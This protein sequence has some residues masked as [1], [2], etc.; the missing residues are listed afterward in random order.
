MS[1]IALARQW[2]PRAFAQLVGQDH[3]NKALIKSL[4]QQRLHHAYLFTGTRG[5]G[6]TSV[7]RLFAKALNCLQGIT[8]EPCLQCD[9]CVAIEEGRFIDLLEID[10]AS[11]TRVEDT[12][13]ILENVH[14]APTSGRFKIYLIDEVHMLSQHSFNALLKVIE[15]PPPHI[16]FL[17][18]TTDPQKLPVTVLSRC[19][20]FH[21]KPISVEQISQQLQ[22]ILVKEQLTFDKQSIDLL[23]EA[24]RGSMRDALSLLDQ[25]IAT[26]AD[27]LHTDTIKNMLG[28]S[29]QDYA[30]K[31]I[32]ALSQHNPALCLSLSREI[33]LEGG[34]FSY[35]LESMLRYFHQITLF[36]QIPDID[37]LIAPMAELKPLSQSFSP[38]D[39]QLFYQI[40]LKGINDLALAPTPLIGFE[41]T[42]LRM[43]AFMPASISNVISA[44]PQPLAEPPLSIAEEKE[45]KEVP[46]NTLLPQLGLSGL[47]K[48]AAEQAEWVAKNQAEITLR[49]AE[50]HRSLFTATVINRIEDALT[51]YYAC[52]LKL[53]LIYE[54]ET[55]S[56]PAQQ[57]QNVQK[58]K[59]AQANTAL[60]EDDFFKR[61]QQEFSGELHEDSVTSRADDL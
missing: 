53:Q 28:Y 47:T 50:S 1:Y 21:L 5:V 42:V 49:V 41:M 56:S 48:H 13:D 30:L 27:H 46:W 17:L 37:S 33:A 34:Q 11:R 2:R 32:Q 16:K 36:Q 6:K 44:P 29:R 45:N 52:T 26:C 20:Q 4:D 57:K 39:V 14:Y 7:A 43:H 61:L 55:S 25:A 51:K 24:A 60:Q 40:A 59:I 23:A 8:S 12:R 58:K 18:A 31:I 54:Q 19:L 35:V 3:V 10:G 38:E 22:L 15:E 9:A